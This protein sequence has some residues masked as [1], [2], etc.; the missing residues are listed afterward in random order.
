M[1]LTHLSNKELLRSTELAAQNEREAT[2]RL[3]HHLCEVQRRRLFAQSGCSSLFDYCVRALKMSEPQAARRVNSARMLKDFPEI[4]G[5]IQSGALSLTA[6]SQAQ[7]FFRK[8]ASVSKEERAEILQKLENQPSRKAEKILLS[9]S[10]SPEAPKRERVQA[11]TETLSELRLTLDQETMENLDRLREIWSHKMPN[12]SVAD[13]VKEMAAYCR[14]KLDPDLKPEPKRRS[15]APAPEGRSIP[16]QLKRAVWKRDKGCC[17]YEDP[18]S[19]RRCGSRYW[20][21]LDHIIPFAYGGKSTVE[22]LRL[23]CRAHNQWHAIETY[24]PGV[25]NY[26]AS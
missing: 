6:V 16:A 15:P 14:Q 19:G 25:L 4:E 20:L 5:K 26:A 24:G 10:S 18:G 13:L 7:V 12:A 23:R 1:K 21:E 9:H 2:T 17:T 3:L 8:E 11:I 22:N